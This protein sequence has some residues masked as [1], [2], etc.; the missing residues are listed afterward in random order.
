MKSFTIKLI[1]AFLLFVSVT[2]EAAPSTDKTTS[3]KFNIPV[4]TVHPEDGGEMSRLP[5]TFERTNT[6][7][8]LKI[9]LA[10][11]TPEGAGASIRGSVWLAAV[12]AAMFR[13]DPMNGVRITVEFSGDV[14][15]PSAGGVM[16]LSVLS[17]MAGRQ[18]PDDFAMTGTIMPDGTI[19][20]VGGVA[21]KVNAAI[22]RG[23]KRIC[24][25]RY[26]RF[27]TQED[28]SVV[29][30]FT[31]G[32]DKNVTVKPVQNIDE[33]YSF[34]YGVRREIKVVDEFALCRIPTKL[35]D[36]YTKVAV[37]AEKDISVEKEKYKEDILATLKNDPFFNH[38]LFS[39]ENKYIQDFFNG[40][41]ISAANDV[42]FRSK[43][44][45]SL[46]GCFEY[47]N[48]IS[49][50]EPLFLKNPPFSPTDQK[51]ILE[52]LKKINK[53]MKEQ[54]EQIIKNL[55]NA[56]GKK[57]YVRPSTDINEI[58]C[59]WAYA[60]DDIIATFIAIS[61]GINYSN[62]DLDTVCEKE[63]N[64]DAFIED[65]KKKI[66]YRKFFLILLE[67]IIKDSN[68]EL[69]KTVSLC[70]RNVKPSSTI[71]KVEKLFYSA[72][73]ALDATLTTDVIMQNDF[74]Q[75]DLFYTSHVFGWNSAHAAHTLLRRRSS[76][77]DYG[78]HVTAT[79]AFNVS[80]L[81][82]ACALY[83][84][85]S[86]DCGSLDA[87]GNYVC[88][89]PQF[90]TYLVRRARESAL[91]SINE[92]TRDGLPCIPALQ[93]FEKAESVGLADVSAD[94]LIHDVLKNYWHADLTARAIM[95]SFKVEK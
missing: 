86:P 22:Q 16:C 93:S 91:S 83:V 2:S 42:W 62:E 7:D 35:E 40:R 25:P 55:E 20:I 66:L 4:L 33:V 59:W 54:E 23:C 11:D 68:F 78:C 41:L 47:F 71:P 8:P 31:L 15:G 88:T 67:R 92:C 81:T 48:K 24:I 77:K 5:F 44:W 45:S 69:E 53:E 46:P 79:L 70:Y 36:V 85:Y 32:A 94:D 56:R 90:L 84:K 76:L 6:D 60:K 21:Q 34:L 61:S 39:K 50:K 49:E 73:R 74:M 3:V 12:T 19:G 1:T 29:D 17:A 63:E 95:M 89:N 37:N 10:N 28:G 52:T 26:P 72:W 87:E 38:M 9:I 80:R 27:E 51:K 57:G 64:R 58:A 82:Q 65:A 13:K 43:L 30:L 18:I 75:N 14:D